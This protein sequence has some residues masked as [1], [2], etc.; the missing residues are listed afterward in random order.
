[1]QC[2]TP[3]RKYN[4]LTLGIWSIVASCIVGAR[5][6][7]HCTGASAAWV[8][9]AVCHFCHFLRTAFDSD[10]LY[11]ELGAPWIL[12]TR[13]TVWELLCAAFGLLERIFFYWPG[14]PLPACG[15]W[16]D[17]GGGSLGPTQSAFAASLHTAGCD[18]TLSISFS[19]PLPACLSPP[20]VFHIQ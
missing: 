4:C 12:G 15:G 2:S 19:D 11:Q 9:L 7:P 6:Q 18:A 13:S 16:R 17:E 14:S 10:I 1:M 8:C 3:V 5:F 20:F